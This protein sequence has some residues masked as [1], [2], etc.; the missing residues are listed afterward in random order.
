MRQAT[1]ARPARPLFVRLARAA[2]QLVGA[3]DYDAYLEHCRRRGHTNP[4]T[5]RA[6][7]REVL[8]RKGTFRCC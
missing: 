5:R 6:Y 2:R 7:V 3:P 4:L 1:K 8:D